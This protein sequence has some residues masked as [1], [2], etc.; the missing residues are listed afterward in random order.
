MNLKLKNIINYFKENNFTISNIQPETEGQDY[1]ATTFQL[2]NNRVIFRTA[3]TTPTKP[4]N[5]VTCWKRNSNKITV[6]FDTADNFTFLII[7]VETGLFI[8]SK[9]DLL[10]NKIITNTKENI[11]KGKNGFRLYTPDLTN[12]N[13][14]ATK[15]QNLQEKYFIENNNIDKINNLITKPKPL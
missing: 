4:G 1:T 7:Q 2:N 15:T 10:E 12:L 8:F 6:P 11:L 14:T 9:K 5:F 13:Q 3:K